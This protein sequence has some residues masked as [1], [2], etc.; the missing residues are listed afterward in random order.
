MVQNATARP[1]VSRIEPG[2][3]ATEREVPGYG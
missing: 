2:L 3:T 1:D